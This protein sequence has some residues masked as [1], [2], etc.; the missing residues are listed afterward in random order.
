MDMFSSDINDSTTLPNTQEYHHLK[1]NNVSTIKLQVI[2]LTSSTTASILNLAA[3]VVLAKTSFNFATKAS[4]LNLSLSNLLT[5]ISISAVDFVHISKESPSSPSPLCDLGFE[6]IQ[7]CV[8]LGHINVLLVT[9]NNVFIVKSPFIYRTVTKHRYSVWAFV[10]SAWLGALV[11]CFCFSEIGKSYL[12]EYASKCSKQVQILGTVVLVSFLDLCC[13]VE[14]VVVCHCVWKVKH[15]VHPCP[16][17]S[18]TDNHPGGNDGGDVHEPPR[19]YALPPSNDADYH[20]QDAEFALSYITLRRLD[21]HP[22]VRPTDNN[23]SQQQEDIPHN[24]AEATPPGISIP[25]LEDDRE[26]NEAIATPTMNIPRPQCSP[27]VTPTMDISHPQF[28]PIATPTM[29]IPHPQCSPGTSR[30]R[31]LH[32]CIT[33]V[34]I[35]MT[36]LTLSLPCSILIIFERV[37]EDTADT[38]TTSPVVN[39]VLR[40]TMYIKLFL[41]PCLYLWRYLKLEQLR[42]TGE[43]L[44]AWMRSCFC[45]DCF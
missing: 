2:S 37:H 20:N 31:G 23:T 38:L 10:L 22:E 8:L 26:H 28:S 5:S 16:C 9:S 4:V 14:N 29:N 12:G 45:L 3:F 25:R 42:K 32:H 6:V 35:S 40:L 27:I 11:A 19:V 39:I 44:F 36:S 24:E 33:L 1:N 30:H 15:Q 18:F 43:E 13:V 7:Y 34:I 21:E 17:N 41:I